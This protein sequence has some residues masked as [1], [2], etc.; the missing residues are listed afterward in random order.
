[1]STRPQSDADVA[2]EP[3]TPVETEPY[4]EEQDWLDHVLAYLKPRPFIWGPAAATL[5][6]IA[7]LILRGC[8][9]SQPIGTDPTVAGRPLSNPDQ[10]LH[11]LAI[12]PIHPG[13]IYLGTHYGLFTST[14]G[15]KT[16]PEKRGQFNTLMIISIA[17]S[18]LQPA[19]LAILG[20]DP[21]YG[22]NGVYITHDGHHWTRA[23]DPPGAT[24]NTQRYLVA[25]G[26]TVHQWFVICD[27]IGLFVTNDDGRTWKFLRAPV[28]DH[29]ALRA[30]WQS[31][32]NPQILMLG[33]NLG[34]YV[35]QDGGATWSTLNGLPQ[36]DG[37]HSI[38]GTPA[39]ANDVYLAADDG[40]YLSSDGGQT[41][42]RQSGLVSSA[43]FTTIS[44]SHQRASVL[45]GLAGNE[46]WRSGDGGA[47]WVQ[48]S[49]LQTSFPSAL[50]VA[51]D[52]DQHLYAGFYAPPDA[53]ESRDGG[54]T[55]HVI[56]S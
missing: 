30:F 16:W 22:N 37:V 21:N 49:I 14:N 33:S 54:K 32:A 52:N 38:A 48:Q 40:V 9:A 12:D 24:S 41:F 28:S 7:V 10:H 6:L 56:A 1:M 23:T 39:A 45:Y 18:P 29:E 34:G 47:T 44:V 46:I 4:A 8:D 11:S 17:V 3:A 53:V 19:T 5:V 31:P 42:A 43:P 51:P 27:G 35:S 2:A 20:M 26:A 15:G 50:I 13:V 55:W 25:Y 36:G